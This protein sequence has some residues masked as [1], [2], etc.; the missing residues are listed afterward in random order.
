MAVPWALP[1]T[2]MDMPKVQQ[3]N[4]GL[5]DG[6]MTELS[7][8]RFALLLAESL[9]IGLDI[10]IR[11]DYLNFYHNGL[12]V[13]ALS[14]HA[15]SPLFR[16]RIHRKYVEGVDL[17]HPMA[18]SGDYRRFDATTEFVVPFVRCLPNLLANA[19]AYAGPE[20]IVEQKMI[21]ASH[22]LGAT[23]A[24]ID[25][26]VQVPGVRKKADLMGLTTNGR[27]VVAEV[28]QGLDNRIQHLMDQIREYHVVVTGPDGRL[29]E[30]IGV[31]YRR[32]IEQKQSLGLLPQHIRPPVDRAAVRCLL[33]LYGYNPLSELL[34]RLRHTAAAST[35]AVD[36]VLL[37][38]GCCELPPDTCW[39]H[40]C[41]VP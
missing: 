38:K 16:A 11:K 30:D 19:E 1:A 37:P 5:S 15:A 4:R 34:T 2:W 26:Q 35:L 24:F 6:F 27:F 33:V 8:G 13:L 31:A 36:L 9:R 29:R 25:R 14:E 28:K 23:V 41:T 3:F 12:S 22:A 18:P 10:Q 20:A 21:P 17:P 39:E 32:V 40:L 7:S